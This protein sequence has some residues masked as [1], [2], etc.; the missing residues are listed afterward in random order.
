MSFID[1]LADY[2]DQEA[3]KF[4]NTRQRHWPE[5]DIL[6]DEIKKQF[7]KKKKLRILELGCGSGRLYGHL[8]SSLSTK[9]ITYT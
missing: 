3:D 2:Y 1:D 4:H 9:E 5:F 8:V 7:P 6:T